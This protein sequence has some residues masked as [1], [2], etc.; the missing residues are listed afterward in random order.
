MAFIGSAALV[1][2]L[3]T[4]LY[5]SGAALVGA[6]RE[7]PQ[8]VVSA[9]RAIYALAGLLTLAMVVLEIAYVRSDFHFTLVAQNSSTDTPTFYKLTAMWSSQAGSLL[10]WAFLLAAFSSAVLRATR[11]T[12]REIVPYATAVLGIVAAFFLM[13]L[14][15]YASPFDTL[16]Q[17]P[18]QGNGLSPLLRYPV[19]MI[20]PPMLYTGYVGFSIPFAFAVGALVTRR[21]GPDWIRA[22]RRY[23]LIAWT[24]LGTGILL[25][26]LWSYA[27]LGWGGYWA[28]DPV[29]NASLMPWLI[30]TA[31]LHSSMV[32][33]KRGMLK[34]WNVSLIMGSFALALIGTFL[35]RS[36]IL[37]SI[38]AFGAS[39][40][41]VP[42]VIFIAL[43]VVGSVLL[44]VSRLDILRA[45]SQLASL[46]SREAVFLLNNLVLVSLAFVIFW[47]TFFPL[48]SEA[49]TGTKASVGPPWFDRYTVPLALVLVLLTA[50]GPMLAWRRSSPRQLGAM[51]RVPVGLTAVVLVGLV[52]LTNAGSS[53]PSLVMFCLVGLALSVVGQELVRG[54]RA[55]R[56]ASGERWP[57][58]A[59]RLIGRNRRRYGG[60]IAHAGLA[61]LFLGVA[62]SSTFVHQRDVRLLPGQSTNVGGYTVSYVRPTV[63]VFNDHAHTGAP[64]S[65]G[66]VV[67][68]RHGDRHEILRPARNLYASRNPEDGGVGRFFAGEA[69]SEV[70]LRWGLR[71]D[72]WTA[73]SPDLRRV[74]GLADIANRKFAHQP[75]SVQTLLAAEIARSWAKDPIPATFRVIVSPLV[76]WV[77]L[78]G[79]ILLC[80]ALIAMWPGADKRTV[81]SRY[82]ARIGRELAPERTLASELTLAPERALAPDRT[83]APERA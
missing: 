35:V 21:T 71:R 12:L 33:E 57:V 34:V 63:G 41:G 30:G 14:V 49:V 27:E 23:T 42:F 78:G 69:T 51:L 9:R 72:V 36:G 29:E 13:L 46:L 31:Y 68:V 50:V 17:A 65:F 6:R 67:D 82:A 56:T 54:T 48:I 4:A 83:L 10:L 26:A 28:W 76:A 5:A 79:L 58:A 11:N 75:A 62:A 81:R 1:C 32:Q 40:L 15:V 60:Y 53:V 74:Q 44:V 16:A 18:A 25:G 73:I 20:H 64:L 47:G 43:V 39:T 66:A 24:F 7:R 8:L 3:L 59:V 61:V 22:T 37:D 19:M 55:R 38:H 77:W 80:G 2:A 70:A 52:V 45:P